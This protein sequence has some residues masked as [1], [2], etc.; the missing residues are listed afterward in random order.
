[1]GLF[2]GVA[3]F[4]DRLASG[5]KTGYKGSDKLL[6]GVL[7]GAATPSETRYR[8]TLAGVT[9]G[10]AA[11]VVSAPVVLVGQ[12]V[13]GWLGNGYDYRAGL[14]GAYA[15][16]SSGSRP[17]S[18][19]GYTWGDAAKGT[20]DT[21]SPDYL[22]RENPNPRAPGTQSGTSPLVDD[23]KGAASK[24]KDWLED[25]GDEFDKLGKGLLV[26][27]VLVIAFLSLDAVRDIKEN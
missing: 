5:I 14:R 16:G 17:P 20:T 19:Q 15:I 24:A 6:G 25:K 21:F 8:D 23:V 26:A 27:G 12:T 4:A 11:A 18:Y 2:D 1:M 10:A 22:Y 7:P 9:T 3:G 13:D